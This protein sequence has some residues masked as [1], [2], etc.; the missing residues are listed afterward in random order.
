[1]VYALAAIVYDK[2]SSTAA[3]VSPA[4]PCSRSPSFLACHNYSSQSFGASSIVQFCF[5]KLLA[6]YS[7]YQNRSLPLVYA[8]S[9]MVFSHTLGTSGVDFVQPSSRSPRS[10]QSSI[11]NLALGSETYSTPGYVL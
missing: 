1:M 4:K 7:A 11:S 9:R 3:F 10:P 5:S 2:Y 6:P 8:P